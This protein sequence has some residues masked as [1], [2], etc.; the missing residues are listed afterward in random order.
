MAIEFPPLLTGLGVAGDPFEE[1]V[2]AAAEAEPGS[3]FYS[4]G[5]ESLQAAVLLVPETSLAD[6]ITVSFAVALGLNDAVGALAPPEVAFHLEWPGLF[7]V[8]GAACGGMRARASTTDP[9]VEPD[10]L[11]IG[12]EV[13]VRSAVADE[14]GA[15]PE[16]TTLEAEGCGALMTVPELIEAWAK[17]MMNWL[18]I[19]LTDGFQPLHAH[20]C[21]RAYRLGETVEAPEPGTFVGL[22]ERGGMILKDGDGMRILPLTRL[23]EAS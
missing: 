14:P 6:A 21:T 8:N 3:V 19:Y 4:P 13:P 23:L 15:T 7:R 1:A 5:E 10:W 11:V 12:L 22:D 20:W 2:V 18:H 17:H 16:R 9:E